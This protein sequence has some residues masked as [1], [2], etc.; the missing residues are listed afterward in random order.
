MDYKPEKSICWGPI[1]TPPSGWT[2]DELMDKALTEAEQCIEKN[3]V[4]VG[5]IV[6]HKDGE[7]IG[8]GH[9][10]P[11]TT[12]DPTAHAEILALRAAGISQQN[13]RFQDCVLV[14][15]LEP[16]L[17]CVGSIIQ[18]RLKGVVYGATELKT[19]SITSCI[20]G[21]NLP[22]NNHKPWHM[23]GIKATQCTQLL[24]N[25]FYNLRK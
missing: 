1:P 20:A 23:G 9:N 11:I 13:Y 14:V 10:T 3:E 15:T 16:C 8:K 2:W 17:M 4:P 7:I 19:G 12:S 5:A 6:I 18:A 25:F 22:F 24:K 21:L